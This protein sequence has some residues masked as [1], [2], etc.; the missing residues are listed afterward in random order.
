MNR[1]GFW[2]RAAAVALVAAFVL[3]GPAIAAE[4][5]KGFERGQSL[6]TAKELKSLMDAK[7]PNLVVI[8]VAKST[9]YALGHIPGSVNIWR[10]DY[11]PAENEPY[12]FGGMMLDRP[13]FEKFARSLGVNNDSLVV[14]YDEKYDA[15]RVWWGFYLFGKTDARILDGGYQAWKAA[16]YDVDRL[17]SPD[18]TPGT[19][20][21][22]QPLGGWLVD[23]DWVWR[24]KTDPEIQLWD[25]REK[26]EWTG[27]KLKKG[28][29]RK[30][31]VPWATFLNWKE[32]KQPVAEGEQYTEF[33][34]AAGVQKVIDQYGMD[35][36]KHQIFYCQSGVRTTTEMFA[37]YL[38]G[39]DPAMLHNYD[40]SWI[41]W[42][43]Y[44]ENPIVAD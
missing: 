31:R 39:W 16:G 11:E 23:L 41:E 8:A 1:S 12:P 17:G 9:D 21:A 34:D 33:K 24:A 25:T 32:F 28:A 30:G 18:V 6:I 42:S 14:I 13:N 7:T 20:T 44:S 27:E 3:V 4:K 36:S 40:G 15:A 37:L 29:F 2:Y 5:Y 43:Y 10:G 38:M 22:T 35:K 26:D 19:F